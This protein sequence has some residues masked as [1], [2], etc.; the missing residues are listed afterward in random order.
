MTRAPFAWSPQLQPGMPLTDDDFDAV[1]RMAW[2]MYLT[3]NISWRG[4]GKVHHA[5]VTLG[6]GFANSREAPQ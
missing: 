1:I 6:E 3:G 2:G 5:L 4:A